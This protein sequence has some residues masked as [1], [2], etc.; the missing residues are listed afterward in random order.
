MREIM[1]RFSRGTSRLFRV[2]AGMGWAGKIR[3]QTAKTMILSNPYPFH[4][5]P[6]GTS[7]LI[8]WHSVVVTPSMVGRKL[9]VF[10]ACETK[11]GRR[12]LTDEQAKFLAAVEA[13]GGVACCARTEED[14][15]A[16]LDAVG[17]APPDT[18][19]GAPESPQDA[20]TPAP[21]RMAPRRRDERPARP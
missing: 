6:A 14:L 2:N 12:P 18:C 21:R 20:P 15:A 13:A 3:S 10:V 8:G 9:A 5:G 16:A 19:A 11:A 1:L 17:G 7:D 4:G